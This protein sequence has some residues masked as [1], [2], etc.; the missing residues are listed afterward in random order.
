MSSKICLRNP[1]GIFPLILLEI[2]QFSLQLFPKFSSD[3]PRNQEKKCTCFIKTFLNSYCYSTMN[4]FRKFTIHSF[5]KVS[6]GFFFEISS[7]HVPWIVSE[8]SL[9][10]HSEFSSED[11][12]EISTIVPLEKF[13]WVYLKH[14][15]QIYFFW[16]SNNSFRNAFSN[17]SRI[18]KVPA[19][20]LEEFLQN[21]SHKLLKKFFQDSR[22]F[23]RDSFKNSL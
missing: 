2:S 22:N 5:R 16:T 17:S 10:F 21:I 11:P 23:P 19:E 7:E 1:S 15:P 20:F 3:Y 12:P 13:P 4:P 9:G 6:H 8:F 18:L 14:P